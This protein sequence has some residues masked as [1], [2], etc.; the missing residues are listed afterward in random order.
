MPLNC[1]FEF[2]Y[3]RGLCDFQ[4][5]GQISTCMSSLLTD[6]VR[7]ARKGNGPRSRK[8]GLE[9]CSGCVNKT[10]PCPSREKVSKWNNSGPE[11]ILQFNL[12]YFVLSPGSSRWNALHNLQIIVAITMTCLRKIIAQCDSED[13]RCFTL[14]VNCALNTLM[15]NL[16][17]D[18]PSRYWTCSVFS[19]YAAMIMIIDE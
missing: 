15:M 3:L 11:F 10:N 8:A 13:H 18:N 2:L 1:C 12:G 4:S 7:A 5:R 14:C 9:P 16:C 6:S 17:Q 19:L